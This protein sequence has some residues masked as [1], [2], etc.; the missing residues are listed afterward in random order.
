MCEPLCISDIDK[1]IRIWRNFLPHLPFQMSTILHT[2]V[3]S[4]IAHKTILTCLV[5]WIAIVQCRVLTTTTAIH[6]CVCETLLNGWNISTQFIHL[7]CGK[8]MVDIFANGKQLF[9]NHELESIWKT[10]RK[11]LNKHHFSFVYRKGLTVHIHT[12]ALLKKM[13]K[14]LI[15]KLCK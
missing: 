8:K 13:S 6:T 14:K 9:G 2:N 1:Y 4:T 11:R 3:D 15:S 10:W 5:L 12:P 7:E